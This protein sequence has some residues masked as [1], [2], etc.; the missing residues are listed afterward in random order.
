MSTLFPWK[1]CT[2]GE[3]NMLFQHPYSERV[4]LQEGKGWGN[5][6][7]RPTSVRVLLVRR[8]VGPGEERW[9]SVDVVGS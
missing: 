4:C 8:W 6:L 1:A 5:Q 3:G 9:S 7:G 2:I